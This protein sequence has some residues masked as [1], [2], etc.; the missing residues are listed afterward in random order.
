MDRYIEDKKLKDIWN[1]FTLY[2][3]IWF[4]SI[5]ILSVVFAFVFPEEDMNGINGKI[6]MALYLADIFLNTEFDGG[7]HENRVQMISDIENR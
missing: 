1:F 7:R 5:L 6:F 3:K 2:E 4:F